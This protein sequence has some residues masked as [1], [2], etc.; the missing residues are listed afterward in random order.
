MQLTLAYHPVTEIHFGP[1]TRLD[2]TTL[3]IDRRN[4][5]GWSWKT[6]QSKA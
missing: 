1:Q 4:C 5:A 2:G 3:V 6:K